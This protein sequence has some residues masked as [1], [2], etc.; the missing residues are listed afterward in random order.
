[1]YHSISMAQEFLRRRLQASYCTQV[2]V[3]V[4][5]DSVGLHEAATEM[6]QQAAEKVAGEAGISPHHVVARM[7]DNMY[8]LEPSN[9]LVLA[10]AVPERGVELFIEIPS[11]LW[12]PA[13]S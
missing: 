11:A 6:L 13:T 7:F 5:P 10:V 9:T 12:R 3:P 8:R 1:M 2:V 4:P